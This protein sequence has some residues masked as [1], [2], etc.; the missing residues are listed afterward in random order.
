MTFATEAHKAAYLSTI[1]D[2]AWNLHEYGPERVLDDLKILDLTA[3]EEL[4]KIVI[5]TDK[6]AQQTAAIFKP[7]DPYFRA[8]ED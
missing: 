5:R 8:S 1:E 3:Y 2:L 6:K 7:K 4:V